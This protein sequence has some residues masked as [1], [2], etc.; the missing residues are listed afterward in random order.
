M[1]LT[2]SFPANATLKIDIWQGHIDPLPLA[3]VPF[4]INDPKVSAEANNIIRVIA[5]DLKSSGLFGLVGQKSFIEKGLSADKRPRFGDWRIVNAQAL[6]AGGVTLLPDGKMS[7]VFRLW[8]VVSET[9]MA[10]MQLVAKLKN[11][12]WVAHLIA[13]EIYESL[14]GDTGYFDSRIVFIDET[15]PK[16]AR[17]KRLAVVEQDGHNPTYLTDG[18]DLVLTPRFSPTAQEVTYLSYAEGEPRVYLLNIET[19]KQEIVGD[20]PGMTFSPRFSPDGNKI[21]MSLARNGNSNIYTMDLTTRVTKRL[22]SSLAIDTGP[23]YSPDGDEIV[24]ESDRAG[25]QQLYIMDENGQKVRRISYGEG[26]YATPVWSPRGDLIAFTKQIRGKFLIGVMHP[27]GSGERVLTQGY[28]NE[29]P[30][31]SPNGRVLGFFREE[32]GRRRGAQLWTVDIT[33]HN[34]RRLKTPHFA[35]DPAWSPLIR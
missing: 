9:Q 17:V 20:F 24:F 22:T 10:G 32:K 33:G 5:A 34:E 35:S 15:G 21:I 19:G 26:S 1:L 4:V 18:K 8:D 30:T 14:T 29:G 6:V 3:I 27:D 31:W 12:R 7:I 28:H 25:Q 11:W 16:N 2:M 23:C 13:D